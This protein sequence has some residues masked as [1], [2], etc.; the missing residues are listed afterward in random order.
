MPRLSTESTSSARRHTFSQSHSSHHHLHSQG[1]QSLPQRSDS[2]LRGDS[3]NDLATDSFDS[4]DDLP[5]RARASGSRTRW[6]ARTSGSPYGHRPLP[7]WSSTELKQLQ[8][9]EMLNDTYSNPGSDDGR[10][11]TMVLEKSDMEQTVAEGSKRRERGAYGDEEAGALQSDSES[12]ADDADSPSSSRVPGQSHP[13]LSAAVAKRRE[14]NKKKKAKARAKAKA[15]ERSTATSSQSVLQLPPPPEELIA[16]MARVTKLLDSLDPEASEDNLGELLRQVRDA[17]TADGRATPLAQWQADVLQRVRRMEDMLGQM[18]KWKVMISTNEIEALKQETERLEV[19]V[20]E[21]LDPTGAEISAPPHSTTGEGQETFAK[22]PMEVE[23]SSSQDMDG[24]SLQ[25]ESSLCTSDN[26]T[27]A[28]EPDPEDRSPQEEKGLRD[29]FPSSKP[30]ATVAGSLSP[31]IVSPPVSPNPIPVL[32]DPTPLP[33]A[34]ARNTYSAIAPSPGIVLISLAPQNHNVPPEPPEDPVE[35]LKNYPWTMVEVLLLLEV[36]AHYPPAEHGWKFIAEAY[37]NLLITRPIQ[38][39]FQRQAGMTHEED[40]KMMALLKKLSIEAHQL[41]TTS[42]AGSAKATNTTPTPKTTTNTATKAKSKAGQR[43][44][45]APFGSAEARAEANARAKPAATATATPATGGSSSAKDAHIVTRLPFPIA[46]RRPA[47][48][49]SAPP[50]AQRLVPFPRRR[51]P[52]TMPSADAKALSTVMRSAAAGQRPHRDESRAAMFALFSA[53]KTRFVARSSW[54]CWHRWSTPWVAQDEIVEQS[55]VPVVVSD[56][57]AGNLVRPF[58]MWDSQGPV[59]Q[60]RPLPGTY[61]NV[62]GVQH[63]VVSQF[64]P[65]AGMVAFTRMTHLLSE[66]AWTAASLGRATNGRISDEVLAARKAR[67]PPTLAGIWPGKGQPMPKPPQPQPPPTPARPPNPLLPRSA[68]PVPPKVAPTGNSLK[69][70]STGTP[71]S[72]A[73]KTSASGQTR[74]PPPQTTGTIDKPASPFR[75]LPQP[76]CPPKRTPPRV[77]ERTLGNMACPG[78]SAWFDH[79]AVRLEVLQRLA[80]PDSRK[81]KFDEALGGKTSAFRE[82]KDDESDGEGEKG[83]RERF[84]LA[85]LVRDRKGAAGKEEK[86]KAQKDADANGGRERG[87]WLPLHLQNLVI[88]PPQ[89]P[90][91]LSGS[92]L[93]MHAAKVKAKAG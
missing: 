44:K 15:R 93:T 47:D 16:S 92:S 75:P 53:T 34:P 74:Q 3:P 4:S 35:H 84:G 27:G 57:V 9:P 55:D 82:A 85:G 23:H 39:W 46:P 18:A 87:A 12:E 1:L 52:I 17:L 30:T 68:V 90:P 14:K 71:S 63:K 79:A 51:P 42:S 32:P 59:I 77:P 22:Q 78:L 64:D 60:Y 72:S 5:G 19:R 25:A 10:A 31:P 24:I 29:N 13:P 66:R 91:V 33:P 81:A 28:S 21:V 80:D 7:R 11:G 37:N 65:R 41:R 69:P 50:P 70:P 40:T 45:A 86:E 56:Y 26:D 89:R 88:P 58:R 73:S 8:M 62:P 54:D 67:P 36:V 20:R 76:S 49:P 38:E 2:P 61:P 83:T 6:N 48:D 43:G